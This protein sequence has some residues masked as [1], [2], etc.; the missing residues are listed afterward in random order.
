MASLKDEVVSLKTHIAELES[1]S[2]TITRAAYPSR[3]V[4]HTIYES[5]V[6][7]TPNRG[8]E[9]GSWPWVVVSE[10]AHMM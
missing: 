9:H 6:D 2:L 5:C 1:S 7:T 3:R 8:D 4:D 10:H